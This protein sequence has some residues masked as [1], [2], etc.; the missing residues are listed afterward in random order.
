VR[1]KR[2]AE[3]KYPGPIEKREVMSAFLC[4]ISKELS[5]T[6]DSLCC[7]SLSLVSSQK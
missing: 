5:R 1:K 2:K 3:N 6:V 4:L 7:R